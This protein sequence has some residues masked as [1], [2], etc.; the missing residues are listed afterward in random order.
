MPSSQQTLFEP[1][2]EY[3]QSGKPVNKK[4]SAEWE[5]QLKSKLENLQKAET[6]LINTLQDLRKKKDYKKL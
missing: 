2:F 6:K 1:G 3:N 5:H 4:Q